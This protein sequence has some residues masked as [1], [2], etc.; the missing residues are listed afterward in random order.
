MITHSYRV[1]CYKQTLLS[2]AVTMIIKVTLMPS[3]CSS[4]ILMTNRCKGEIPVT[5]SCSSEIPVTSI[6]RY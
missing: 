3:S 2:A 6:V 1:N 5:S 4:E